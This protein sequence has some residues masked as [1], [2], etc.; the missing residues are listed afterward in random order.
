MTRQSS[1]MYTLYIF[2]IHFLF[3][4]V[5]SVLGSVIKNQYWS[6]PWFNQII[7]LEA[8]SWRYILL[9]SRI[10][11]FSVILPKINLWEKHFHNL[12]QK[13]D[14]KL[15]ILKHKVFGKRERT[16]GQA[17]YTWILCLHLSVA[18]TTCKRILPA[19]T[20]VFY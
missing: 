10:F 3:R 9:L 7:Y 15:N 17:L 20:N 19:P 11:S 16:F 6:F 1:A 14:C 12:L 2:Y 5:D 18:K 13:I 4:T 8:L